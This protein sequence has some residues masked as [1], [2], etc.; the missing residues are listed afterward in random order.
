M[1]ILFILCLRAPEPTDP[2]EPTE[3]VIHALAL[4]ERLNDTIDMPFGESDGT[5]PYCISYCRRL[6]RGA[7]DEKL[8]T[9]HRSDSY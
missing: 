9:D 4:G 3:R 8:E 5:F 2:H 1:Q 6:N 7:Q